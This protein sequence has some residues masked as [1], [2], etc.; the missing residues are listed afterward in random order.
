MGRGLSRSL[1]TG[2]VLAFV[3]LGLSVMPTVRPGAQESRPPDRDALAILRRKCA[4]CHGEAVQMAG[5]DLR[6]RE[7]LLKGGE[8]G[9][10]IVPGDAEASRLYRRVA[11]LEKPVMPWRRS[12][13]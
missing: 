4:Q 10:A 3:M 6:T 9:A 13:R 2:C 12:P 5:L 7:S 8:Q 11:G 1:K